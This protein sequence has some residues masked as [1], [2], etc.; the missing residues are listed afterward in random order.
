MSSG[1]SNHQTEIIS[2]GLSNTIT[3][4]IS[5][6]LTPPSKTREILSVRKILSHCKTI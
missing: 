4:A 2:Q 6:R 5:K 3:T 1:A